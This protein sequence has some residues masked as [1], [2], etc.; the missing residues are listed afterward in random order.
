MNKAVLRDPRLW[1]RPLALVAVSMGLHGFLLWLPLVESSLPKTEEMPPEDRIK[2]TTLPLADAPITEAPAA[3]LPKPETPWPQPSPPITQRQQQRPAPQRQ[4]TQPAPRPKPEPTPSEDR[5]SAPTNPAPNPQPTPPAGDPP[6]N[7]T[8]PPGNPTNPPGNPTPPNPTGD[9][10]ANF[11][12]YPNAQRGSESLFN[13][14]LQDAAQNTPDALPTV[15]AFYQ[16]QGPERDFTLTVAHEG[17]GLK[18]YQVAIANVTPR[19]LHLLTLEQKTVMMLLSE[20]LDQTTLARLQEVENLTPE[21][22]EFEQFFAQLYRDRAMADFEVD[23]AV[24]ASLPPTL[25]SDPARLQPR[26]KIAQPLST[27]KSDVLERMRQN[28]RYFAPMEIVPGTGIYSVNSELP[29]VHFV[30]LDGGQATGV[31]TTLP[32]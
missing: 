3:E 15:A 32:Q 11:P 21:E 5:P 7:P 24:L 6:V 25:A 27:A 12:A 20:P 17:E 9:P 13:P 26:G 23:G 30:A 18:V 28:N 19:Y 10:F 14:V 8:D 22:R 2:V 31:I 16:E 1:V 29:L 4:V